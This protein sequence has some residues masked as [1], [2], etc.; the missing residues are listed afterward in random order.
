MTGAALAK[1]RA[2]A[3][4]LPPELAEKY[5]ADWLAELDSLAD[6]PLSAIGYA[7]G[8]RRGA[9]RIASQTSGFE[10]RRLSLPSLG[11]AR[12]RTSGRNSLEKAYR[13]VRIALFVVWVAS[14]ALALRAVP[15]AIHLVRGE[16]SAV[17]IGLL[18]VALFF[19]SGAI[20]C[21]ALILHS[22][23]RTSERPQKNL[24]RIRPPR[25]R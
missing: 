22:S 23:R 12:R 4:L 18:V 6:K 21:I 8:L 3:K 11:F 9:R 7:R 1:A 10:R 16:F 15:Q 20:I 14:L 19:S 24:S 2:A 13:I 5:E 17:N 25:W